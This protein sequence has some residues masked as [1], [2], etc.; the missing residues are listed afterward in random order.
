MRDTD[1]RKEPAGHAGAV[2]QRQAQGVTTHLH[3]FKSTPCNWAPG[4]WK[5]WQTSQPHPDMLSAMR[6]I[7]GFPDALRICLRK[8]L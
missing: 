5:E 6:A 1:R 2:V 3:A 4:W 7:Q 8:L